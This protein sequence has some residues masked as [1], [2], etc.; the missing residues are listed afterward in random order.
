MQLKEYFFKLSFLYKLIP[1]GILMKI[2]NKKLIHVFYHFV[3][4]TEN[5]LI[6]HLYKAKTKSQF[7][8]DICFFKKHFDVFSESDL[9]HNNGGKGVLISFDDGLANFYEVV[10]PILIKKNILAINFLNSNFIDNKGLFYRYKVNLLIDKIQKE[11]LTNLQI[12]AL[13]MLLGIPNYTDKKMFSFLK[14]AS[15]KE[16][17]ILNKIAKILEFSFED[18]LKMKSPYLTHQQLEELHSKGF[19]FGAHSKNHPR[20]SQISL[21]E[22]L[23]ETL[24][25]VREVKKQFNPKRSL[26]SFPFSDDGVVKE[27]FY[28]IKDQSIITF[29]TSGLKD[30]DL[31]NHFQR[32]PME[33]KSAVYSAETI[34]KGELLY[35]LFKK[36][37]KKHLT[38]RN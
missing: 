33:Y 11:E 10:A 32:I 35:Y 26:F 15:I 36:I 29:G 38:N 18:Y 28:K 16:E 3:I 6:G 9:T 34:V 23:A 14:N 12:R 7:T 5:D 21:E 1:L 19:S 13:Q 25:S 24:E 31:D 37:F 20:Y 30:E 22:Q 27:F 17:L 2:S 8:E 4:D